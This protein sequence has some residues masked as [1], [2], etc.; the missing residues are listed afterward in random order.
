MASPSATAE[1]FV[2]V[3]LT[4]IEVIGTV[5]ERA[6]EVEVRAKRVPVVRVL[7]C[8]V[9]GVCDVAEKVNVV[10]SAAGKVSDRVADGLARADQASE[11]AAGAGCHDG[12][13]EITV[14]R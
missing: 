10:V 5:P 1:A 12:A 7:V 3:P 9:I 8:H 11:E 13:P 2:F 4:V 6:A 14:R